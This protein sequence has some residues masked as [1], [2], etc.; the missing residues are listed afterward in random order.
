MPFSISHGPNNQGLLRFHIMDMGKNTFTGQ[1][2]NLVQQ[3]ENNF[4]I[5]VDGPYGALSIPIYQSYST[6]ILC[7]GG[8]G[9][10]PMMSILMELNSYCEKGMLLDVNE[11]HFIW[12]A[13]SE[14]P[15]KLWFPNLSKDI[16]SLTKEGKIKL[17]LYAT[18]ST[19]PQSKPPPQKKTYT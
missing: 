2:A 14:E 1:L 6:I 8:I 15:F 3:N 12:A 7:A 11:I 5:K 4:N 18:R 17:H 13:K 19:K 10:T 16:S 9:I